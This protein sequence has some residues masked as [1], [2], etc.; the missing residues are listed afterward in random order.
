MG[1]ASYIKNTR[2]GLG[3][4]PIKILINFCAISTCSVSGSF[5]NTVYMWLVL[6]Q[7]CGHFGPTLQ[8]ASYT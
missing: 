4:S 2:G 8:L 7:P 3:P 6:N 1:E 5:M